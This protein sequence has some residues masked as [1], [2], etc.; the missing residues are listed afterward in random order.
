MLL[1][2]LPTQGTKRRSSDS[3][4]GS[5][6]FFCLFIFLS[7]QPAISF[8]AH[9][10]S[11]SNVSIED[12]QTDRQTD[13]GTFSNIIQI[14]SLHF[15]YFWHTFLS[16]NSIVFGLYP[17]S[18]GAYPIICPPNLLL[19]GSSGKVALIVFFGKK[20]TNT[21]MLASLLPAQRWTRTRVISN[22]QKANFIRAEMR[23]T[24]TP[25]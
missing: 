20:E 4:W 10:K 8:F 15:T 18:P 19:V 16:G 7:N 23:L 14:Y 5:Q 24:K 12:R 21:N 2:S 25:R 1:E 3:E 17:F 9:C 11:T 6:L 22:F 13:V